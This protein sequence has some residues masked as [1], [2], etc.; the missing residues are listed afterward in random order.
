MAGYRTPGIAEARFA[1]VQDM[2]FYDS[3]L[4]RVIFIFSAIGYALAEMEGALA[5]FPSLSVELV[6][7]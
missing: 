4:I 3:L 6:H 2:L 7:G 1:T 5:V